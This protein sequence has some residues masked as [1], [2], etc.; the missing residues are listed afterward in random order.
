MVIS[1][2]PTRTLKESVCVCLFVCCTVS[3]D[4]CVIFVF[5][6]KTLSDFDFGAW[7]QRYVSWIRVNKFRVTDFFRQENK[8]GSGAMLRKNFVDGMLASSERTYIDDSI[9][10]SA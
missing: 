1:T 3:V 9:N 6:Q 8:K 4:S 5:Q 7:R 10:S 2:V